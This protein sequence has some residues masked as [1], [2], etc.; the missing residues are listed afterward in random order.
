MNASGIVSAGVRSVG[1]VFATVRTMWER[2]VSPSRPKKWPAGPGYISGMARML[3]NK[4]PPLPL[5]PV[6]ER[7]PLYVI[8]CRKCHACPATLWKDEASANQ[9]A[10]ECSCGNRGPAADFISYVPE[11]TVGVWA[12]QNV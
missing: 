5:N 6:D 8:F 7:P 1:R 12:E 10:V 11:G 4:R 3:W 9:H 2:A